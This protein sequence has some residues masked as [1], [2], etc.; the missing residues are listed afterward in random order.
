MFKFKQFTIVHGNCPAKVGTDG[1]LLGAWA[2]VLGIRTALDVGTGSGVIAVMLA[3]RNEKAAIKGL[4][5]Q[6]DCCTVAAENFRNSPW[7]KRLSL[8]RSTLQ[9]FSINERHSF[10]LIISNP[11]Y[12]HGTKP[13]T[14]GKQ[15]FRHSENLPHRELLRAG[16]RLLS[17]KGRLCVILPVAE[18]R[19]LVEGAGDFRLFLTKKTVV[20]SKEK[21][22]PIRWLM[23]FE[24]TKKNTSNT[25]LI[26]REDSGAWSEEYRRLVGAFYL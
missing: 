8:V 3:Q 20:F 4:E 22:K 17:G 15:W 6:A 2:D 10:D 7:A 24:K 13:K 23:Q 25:R 26:L 21:K 18:A 14:K 16:D 12:F 1:V 19:S 9:D 5:I 11:P